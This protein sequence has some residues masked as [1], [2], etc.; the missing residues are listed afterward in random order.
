MR[1]ILILF[2]LRAVVVEPGYSVRIDCKVDLDHDIV[3]GHREGIAFAERDADCLKVIRA[4]A[5]LLIEVS[6]I[7][8]IAFARRCRERDRCSDIGRCRI[9]T[10]FAVAVRYH[11]RYGVQLADVE[12]AAG[13]EVVPVVACRTEVDV[14]A[15]GVRIVDGVVSAVV[16]IPGELRRACRT[17]HLDLFADREVR[18]VQDVLALCAAVRSE[19]IGRVGL[20]ARDRTDQVV[21]DLD[22]LG[23]GVGLA[24]ER[25]RRGEDQIAVVFRRRD[26]RIDGFYVFIV[27]LAGERGGRRRPRGRFAAGPGP[28]GIAP[29]MSGCRDLDRLGLRLERFVFELCGVDRAACL[30]AGRV[31]CRSRRGDLFGLDVLAV[32]VAD[33]GRGAG[34]VVAFLCPLVSRRSPVMAGA[35]DRDRLV[36]AK[37]DVLAALKRDDF[38]FRIRAGIRRERCR[39]DRG[40]CRKRILTLHGVGD[41]DDALIVHM[42]GDEQALFRTLCAA[43]VGQ[44][45]RIEAD[46]EVTVRGRLT[47]GKR[48]RT[49]VGRSGDRTRCAVFFGFFRLDRFLDRFFVN[50]LFRF[51]DRLLVDRLF[52]LFDRLFVDR[53]FRLFDR[54]FVD[55]FF[56]IDDLGVVFLC[57]RSETLHDFRRHELFTAHQRSEVQFADEFFAHDL[58]VITDGCGCERTVHIQTGCRPYA[59]A[60]GA[61]AVELSACRGIRIRKDVQDRVVA[62]LMRPVE[63]RSVIVDGVVLETCRNAGVVH[64]RRRTEA[65]AGG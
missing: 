50:R 1:Y 15:A 12:E 51:F 9:N 18:D 25:R 11:D 37:L 22:A 44:N 45:V 23:I 31:G 17:D 57:F 20:P 48:D 43:L 36:L 41:G 34:P 16:R 13:E 60:E 46:G 24:V 62:V 55:R 21:A 35:R 5:D 26:R 14:H 64:K 61:C 2:K 52:R 53:F 65:D 30:C 59:V 58:V 63:M 56:L 28:F 3:V 54:L 7:E 47:L 6:M 39:R 33:A 42:D 49:A 32:V 19:L 40:F 38:D 27:V 8:V 29:N 4:F 10:R